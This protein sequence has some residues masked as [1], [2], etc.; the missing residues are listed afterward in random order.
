MNESYRYFDVETKET[1]R[2]L[3]AAPNMELAEEAAVK[4]GHSV[5]CVTESEG[6]GWEEAL[7][8]KSDQA[9]YSVARLWL[10][11]QEPDNWARFVEI[12]DDALVGT[13]GK[14]YEEHPDFQEALNDHLAVLGRKK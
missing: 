13:L 6:A 1:F 2:L 3:V 9:R 12:A 7:I 14:D 10:L 8:Y 11:L 4:A 5:E